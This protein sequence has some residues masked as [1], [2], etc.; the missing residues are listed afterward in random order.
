Q[1]ELYNLTTEGDRTLDLPL[2][3]FG[4]KGVFTR[5]IE[6]ALLEGKIDLAVH[7]VK[8]LPAELPE[9][10]ELSAVLEREDPRDCFISSN[11]TLL[12]ELPEGSTIGT[13][14]VRRTAQIKRLRPDFVPQSVRGNVETRLRKLSEHHYDALVMAFAGLKRLGLDPF[15]TQML[16]TDFFLPAGGQGI[17]GIETRAGDARVLDLCAAVN[18]KPTEIQSDAERTFLKFLEGGCQ[19]PCGVLSFIEGNAIRIQALVLAPDG[20]REIRTVRTGPTETACE[21]ARHAADDLLK[22]GAK[23]LMQHE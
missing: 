9:G 16:D 22:Q 2:P 1:I 6:Q 4:G 15:V 11:G 5:E 20:R 7:S 21:L 19:V 23:K 8:D 13:S 17:I 18:H 3:A 14:S 12:M 10:L